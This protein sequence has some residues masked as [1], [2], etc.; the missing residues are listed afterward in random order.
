MNTY[1]I[2]PYYGHDCD[3]TMGFN[4][5]NYITEITVKAEDEDQAPI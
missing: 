5:G 1:I 4:N 3:S 2:R